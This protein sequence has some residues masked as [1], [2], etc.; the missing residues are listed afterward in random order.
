MPMPKVVIIIGTRPEAIKLI[1]LYLELKSKNIKV[2]I[3]NTGQHEQMLLPLFELFKVKPDYN[4]GLMTK[5]QSLNQFAAKA[6]S[7]IDEVLSQLYTELIVVQGD[8]TTAMI[9]SLAGFYKHI[10]VAHVEVGLRI[11]DR[12]SPYPEEINRR[13]IGLTADFHFV[14]TEKSKQN[15]EREGVEHIL[16]TGNTVIDGLLFVQRNVELS[17]EKCRKKFSGILG[18]FNIL[19]TSHRRESFGDDFRN[20]CLAIR[21]LSFKYPNFNFIYPVHLNP[22]IK[23]KTFE[24]LEGLNNVKLINPVNYDEMVFLMTQSKIILT[25]S[26]GIQEEAPS[27]NIPLLVM[28]N[29][30]ERPEGIEVGCAI[31]TGTDRNSLIN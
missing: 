15:L 1:P 13:I 29:V 2:K 8:T 28:R 18:N 16:V 21:D 19:I 26:G 30:T 20:I 27:L 10:K 12:F 3:I 31:L 6:L 14:P 7:R 24:F 17:P 22:N 5:N 4:L 23:D 11:Y 25:D 9:A